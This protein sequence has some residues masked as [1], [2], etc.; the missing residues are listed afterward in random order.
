MRTLLFL[1]LIHTAS[2]TYSGE[3]TLLSSS[4]LNEKWLAGEKSF[5]LALGEDR[6]VHNPNDILGLLI[7]WDY[8]LAF[9]QL[10]EIK[11]IAPRL[12][13]SALEVNTPEFSRIRPF[14]LSDL[15]TIPKLRSEYPPEVAEAMA[16]AESHKG[17]IKGKPMNTLLIIKALETDGYFKSENIKKSIAKLPPPPP[18]ASTNQVFNPILWILGAITA[19]VAVVLILRRKKSKA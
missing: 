19:L 18:T 11:S 6:L 17:L 15:E 10:K 9:A 1:V 2:F 5:V 7:K 14:W 8:A 12:H 4:Y 13:K 3:A 16:A